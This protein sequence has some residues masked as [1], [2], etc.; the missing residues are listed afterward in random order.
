MQSVFNSTT[1][2]FRNEIGKAIWVFVTTRELF[3]V[4]L[5]YLRGIQHEQPDIP[6]R[7]LVGH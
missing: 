7:Y 2:D 4:R 5:V 3:V 1:Q 6:Y